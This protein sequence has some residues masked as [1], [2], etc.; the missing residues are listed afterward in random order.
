MFNQKILEVASKY[1]GQKELKN[2]SGFVDKEFEEKMKKMGWMKGQAWCMYFVKLCI[3]E[4]ALE[5][6]GEKI[7]TEKVKGLGGHVL[8][9]WQI[10]GKKYNKDFSPKAGEIGFMRKPGTTQGHVFIVKSIDNLGVR[11]IEGNTNSVGGRE[12]DGVYEKYRKN[13]SM[14]N[15]SNPLKLLGYINLEEPL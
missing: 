12:G 8:T 3:Y 14:M 10:L 11:T 6:Y 13:A 2:N 9:N 4:A 15:D 7:A 1:I 5:L